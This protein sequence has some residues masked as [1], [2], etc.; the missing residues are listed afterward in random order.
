MGR[1]STPCSKEK[2]V[3]AHQT[4]VHQTSDV[5]RIYIGKLCAQDFGEWAVG[6][7]LNRIVFV[8]GAQMISGSS[9][10]RAALGAMIVGFDF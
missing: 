3:W 5:Q 6:E 9:K 2:I 7:I 4:L 1:K 8:I 10:E